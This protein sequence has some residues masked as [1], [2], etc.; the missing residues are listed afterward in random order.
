MLGSIVS[1]DG[2]DFSGI[3]PELQ[4]VTDEASSS[5]SAKVFVG[6]DT[7]TNPEYEVVGIDGGGNGGI[8]ALGGAEESSCI[9]FRC[10]K[11]VCHIAAYDWVGGIPPAAAA[12]PKWGGSGKAG[13]GGGSDGPLG[14]DEDAATAA[15]AAAAAALG[16]HWN[17][18]P[19]KTISLMRVS[20]GV[21]PTSRTK[22]NCSMTDE[23]TVLRLGRRN[24][25]F[26]KRVGWLGYWLLQYSSRAHCDFS[27]NCS[28]IW[29]S[30]NP[31]AS[32]YR[33]TN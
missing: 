6:R 33:K 11:N 15:A 29:T 18:D 16:G 9:L 3:D 32:K 4:L 13:C 27:C 28:I 19:D 10:L 17:V 26:P 21:F 8:A 2:F 1:S 14:D 23:D 12:T 7:G 5:F 31:G 24:N 20:I 30:L 22:N 25:N